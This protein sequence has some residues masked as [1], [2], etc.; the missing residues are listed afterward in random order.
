MCTLLPSVKSQE[1]TY[2]P[3]SLEFQILPLVT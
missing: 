1:F 3:E 2:L